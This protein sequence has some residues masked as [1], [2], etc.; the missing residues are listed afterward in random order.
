MK[1]HFQPFKKMAILYRWLLVSDSVIERKYMLRLAVFM[2]T[3]EN[4][5]DTSV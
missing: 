5:V 4:K 3:E 1:L 2:Q